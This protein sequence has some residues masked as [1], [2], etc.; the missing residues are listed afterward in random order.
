MSS[1]EQTR[2]VLA[3]EN[4]EESGVVVQHGTVS[5]E[6]SD[7]LKG[8]VLCQH[9]PPLLI[10]FS[11]SYVDPLNVSLKSWCLAAENLPGTTHSSNSFA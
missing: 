5:L 1:I 7:R 11:N 10:G 9:A 4:R 8:A 3:A 2:T 6:G